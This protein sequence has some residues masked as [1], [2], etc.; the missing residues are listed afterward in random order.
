MRGTRNDLHKVK[1]KI[2][3]HTI[4]KRK[5]ER[6]NRGICCRDS[7]VF[8]FLWWPQSWI[9]N[10]FYTPQGVYGEAV[11]MSFE[12]YVILFIFYEMLMRNTEK[13]A[14]SRKKL[15]LC[16]ERETTSSLSRLGEAAIFIRK[17][18]APVEDVG[19][20]FLSSI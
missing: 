16:A 8:S 12:S 7:P 10:S 18:N 13:T 17:E 3:R 6:W 2:A 19:R 20:N 11:R 14:S 1:R 15:L 5:K 4:E 9:Q